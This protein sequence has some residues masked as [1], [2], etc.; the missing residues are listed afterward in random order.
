MTDK[1][2]AK[3]ERKSGKNIEI[4]IGFSDAGKTIAS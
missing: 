2:M 4:N 1:K 3:K